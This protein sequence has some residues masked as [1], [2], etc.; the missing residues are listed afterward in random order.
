MVIRF[1]VVFVGKFYGAS[2]AD[3]PDIDY[4]PGR[5]PTHTAYRVGWYVVLDV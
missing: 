3:K 4:L 1:H 2:I 5:I